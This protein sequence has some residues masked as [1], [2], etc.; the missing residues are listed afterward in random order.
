MRGRGRDERNR[1]NFGRRIV[2]RIMDSALVAGVVF[3]GALLAALLFESDG[4]Q[5]DDIQQALLIA[6][7]GGLAELW[8]GSRRR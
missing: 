1:Q 2:K 4:I 3:V 7:M 6:V 5:A 8:I